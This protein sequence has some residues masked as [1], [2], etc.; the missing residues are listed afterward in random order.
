[1]KPQHDADDNSVALIAAD[2]NFASA[3][4]PAPPRPLWRHEQRGLLT[5][6]PDVF[7]RKFYGRDEI[8]D[9]EARARRGDFATGPR[10][11]AAIAAAKK[12]AKEKEG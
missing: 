1:M 10:G 2:T 12:K 5:P 7:G 9:F 11:A 6:I 4:I 8:L 3:G